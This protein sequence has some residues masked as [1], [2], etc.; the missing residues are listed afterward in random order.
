M[1]YKSPFQNIFKILLYD[2][3]AGPYYILAKTRYQKHENAQV[4]KVPQLSVIKTFKPLLHKL[5]FCYFHRYRLSTALTWNIS[6]YFCSI[7]RVPK[8]K[9]WKV[10]SAL[11]YL[12]SHRVFFQS[13]CS[14]C[15]ICQLL[16][17]QYITFSSSILYYKQKG[18]D[19]EEANRNS[20]TSILCRKSVLSASNAYVPIKICVTVMSH[21]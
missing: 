15:S 12:I 18:N 9:H 20:F 2:I 8:W 5:D 14:P 7:E 3:T 1:S 16:N 6:T 21:G 19:E 17:H 10:Q 13:R 4:D 11:L